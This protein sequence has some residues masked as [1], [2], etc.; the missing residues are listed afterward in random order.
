MKKLFSLSVLIAVSVCMCSQNNSSENSK[1]KF[2][3][4][5]Q[6]SLAKD[7]KENVFL[8]FG[9]PNL[10]M[11]RGK[12]SVNAGMFPSLRYNYDSKNLVPVLGAGAQV[13]WKHLICGCVFY[14]INNSWYASPAI[15]YKF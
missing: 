1:V 9:G 3:F 7:M 14:G 8:T 2:D 13:S 12:I 15:G 10:K 6:I 5:G 4:T 11:S